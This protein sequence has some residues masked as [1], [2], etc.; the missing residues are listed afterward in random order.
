MKCFLAAMLFFLTSLDCHSQDF[1]G[2]LGYRFGMTK[3]E[4][5]AAE[6]RSHTESC[7]Y[8]KTAFC[9][10]RTVLI[11]GNIGKVEALFDPNFSSS[12][13]A[14]TGHREFR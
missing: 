14:L 9:L 12:N 6:P 1:R 5:I 8:E 3:N 4:A 11:D 7:S 10:R 2:F 13:M